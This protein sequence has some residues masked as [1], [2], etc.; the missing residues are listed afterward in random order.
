MKA[1]IGWNALS[2]KARASAVGANAAMLDELGIRGGR[3]VAT[4]ADDR[5]REH[6]MD[7]LVDK[8]PIANALVRNR[9][10]EVGGFTPRE[11]SRGPVT[12]EYAQPTL[13]DD[14]PTHPPRGYNP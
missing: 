13:Y 10:A 8:H 7:V 12:P 14:R 5:E 3:A 1:L 6:L 9:K 2:D 4:L 11:T